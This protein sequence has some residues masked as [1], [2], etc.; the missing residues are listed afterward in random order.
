M[1][2]V[3]PERWSP[4]QFDVGGDWPAERVWGCL[5]VPVLVVSIC[6]G[7]WWLR[8]DVHPVHV[9][10][11]T[12]PLIQVPSV[13]AGG[14]LVWGGFVVVEGDVG[15]W[16]VIISRAGVMVSVMGLVGLAHW[17]LELKGMVLAGRADVRRS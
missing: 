2:G 16:N 11:V 17:A 9:H 10:V 5:F 12:P 13:E 3:L 8:P 15:L 1:V 6:A 4:G 7:R 14:E